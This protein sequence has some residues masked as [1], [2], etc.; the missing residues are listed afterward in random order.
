MGIGN[1]GRW[2]SGFWRR[3]GA[4]VIDSAILGGAGYGLGLIFE[5]QFVELGGWSRLVG[6]CIA[7][8]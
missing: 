7:L 5:K 6:F 3:I 4:F 1:D 2:I 8:G